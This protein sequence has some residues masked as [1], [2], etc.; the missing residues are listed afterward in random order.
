MKPHRIW[1]LCRDIGTTPLA[2]ISEF[3]RIRLIYYLIS[4]AQHPGLAF[5]GN[6]RPKLGWTD[7]DGVP[8]SSFLLLMTIQIS[9]LRPS[10]T[11]LHSRFL[12]FGETTHDTVPSHGSCSRAINKAYTTG[13]TTGKLCFNGKVTSSVSQSSL[14]RRSNTR[15]TSLY[16]FTF[17]AVTA[18]SGRARYLLLLATPLNNNLLFATYH[19]FQTRQ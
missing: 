5:T 12:P 13:T 15:R 1:R 14:L 9:S 16:R 6:S 10:S 19:A 7:A 11:Q 18:L 4:G 2:E 17:P 8:P 3:S